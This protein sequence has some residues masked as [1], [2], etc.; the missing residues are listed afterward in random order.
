MREGSRDELLKSRHPSQG[1]VHE[2]PEDEEK[3]PR[4]ASGTEAHFFFPGINGSALPLE[5]APSLPSQAVWLRH[6]PSLEGIGRARMQVM[7]EDGKLLSPRL[8]L[9]GNCLLENVM[10]NIL[11]QITPNPGN[12]VSQGLKDVPLNM[13]GRWIS[14]EHRRLLCRQS[15]T[16]GPCVV[17]HAFHSKAVQ[18]VVIEQNSRVRHDR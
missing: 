5:V 14:S 11:R 1:G 18:K 3:G 4:D 9:R 6:C 13:S 15:R 2:T 7:Q 10:L 8:A 16:K 12:C 17:P